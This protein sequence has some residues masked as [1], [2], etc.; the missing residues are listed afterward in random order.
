VKPATAVLALSVSA[1]ICAAAPAVAQFDASVRPAPTVEADPLAPPVK[2]KARPDADGPP[3]DPT[4]TV[5]PEQLGPELWRG[6][7]V[8]MAA[9]DVTKLFP[10]ARPSK[11]EVRADLT[12]SGLLLHIPFAGAPAT[13]QFYFKTGGL[14]AVII[15]R[16]DVQSGQTAENLQ[17]A[18]AIVDDLTAQYGPPHR[19]VEQPQVTA[20]TC[21][22]VRGPIKVLASYRDMG[23]A[24]PALSVTYRLLKEE[25]IW[26]PGPVKK[27]RGR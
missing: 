18:H 5:A 27:L 11:G 26:T 15:D 3:V 7:R 1:L 10:E 2:A 14:I 21:D 22:W 16:R 25:K 24:L 13:V 9:P 4:P 20:L 17:I 12:K 23:G 19:C 8:G 6:A